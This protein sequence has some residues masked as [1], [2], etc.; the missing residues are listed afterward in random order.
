M[1]EILTALAGTIIASAIMVSISFSILFPEIS[2]RNPVEFL[3]DNPKLIG[4]T[5]LGSTILYWAI[6]LYCNY[7]LY[8]NFEP[9]PD[10][11]LSLEAQWQIQLWIYQVITLIMF[12]FLSTVAFLVFGIILSLISKPN[13]FLEFIG[14]LL[15]L[16]VIGIIL[17]ISLGFVSGLTTG[18]VKD[19]T[20]PKNNSFKPVFEFTSLL[21]NQDDNNRK[22]VISVL[23]TP[24]DSLSFYNSLEKV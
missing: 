23:L 9:N 13:S 14:I 3:I 15:K 20:L 5:S 19:L 4:W 17:G 21:K 11:S 1:N 6:K 24:L 22:K 8:Q 12:T 18:W 7:E 10:S 16:S 2:G